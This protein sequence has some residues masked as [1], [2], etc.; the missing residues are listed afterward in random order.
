MIM[1]TFRRLHSQI[2]LDNFLELTLMYLKKIKQI[3]MLL[4]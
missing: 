1:W 4:K 2:M 3:V